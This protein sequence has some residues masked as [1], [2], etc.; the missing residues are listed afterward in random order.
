[1]LPTW[2]AGKFG[3]WG[4]Y[5]LNFPAYSGTNYVLRSAA[6]SGLA[7]ATNYTVSYWARELGTGYYGHSIVAGSTVSGGSR[8]YLQQNG[9]GVDQQMYF[10]YNNGNFLGTGRN[11][12]TNLWTLVT[13]TYDNAGGGTREKIYLNGVVSN[14]NWGI[15]FPAHAFFFLGG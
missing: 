3:N 13:A 6:V 11:L 2:I 14:Y 15:S 8:N 1:M 9:S 7:G 4:D 10:G 5:A 12:T